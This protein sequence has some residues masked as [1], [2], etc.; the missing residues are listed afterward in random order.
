MRRLEGLPNKAIL[1][2]A[3]G[4]VGVCGAGVVGGMLVERYAGRTDPSPTP[5]LRP[6][7]P[8]MLATLTPMAQLPRATDVLPTSMLPETMVATAPATAVAIRPTVRPTTVVVEGVPMHAKALHPGDTLI[9]DWGYGPWGQPG[10]A[11]PK[12]GPEG[13]V[14]KGRSQLITDFNGSNWRDNGRWCFVMPSGAKEA[15]VTIQGDAPASADWDKG[16]NRL[17]ITSNADVSAKAPNALDNAP[18]PA[19]GSSGISAAVFTK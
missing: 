7:T 6:V 18:H 5:Y 19:K 2:G 16:S 13:N 8:E 17:C 3:V 4:A 15:D 1:V 10:L 14:P 12:V 9:P 11:Y